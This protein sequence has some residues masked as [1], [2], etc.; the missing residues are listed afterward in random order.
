MARVFAIV[1]SSVSIGSCSNGRRPAGST[2]RRV[3]SDVAVPLKLD[4]EDVRLEGVEG[5]GGEV[6]DLD[7]VNWDGER[8]N[9]DF[10][11]RRG[12][13]HHAP[14]DEIRERQAQNGQRLVNR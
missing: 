9:A 1:A 8:A 4:C 5:G 11:G 3:L 10:E 6:H 2:V 7:R 12:L 13:G 14:A